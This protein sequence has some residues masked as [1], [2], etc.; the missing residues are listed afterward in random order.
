[1]VIAFDTARVV[2]TM[3]ERRVRLR[4]DTVPVSGVTCDCLVM[5]EYSRLRDFAISYTTSQID[6][7]DVPNHA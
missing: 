5:E 6:R 3:G 1:M 7:H 4:P 2:H